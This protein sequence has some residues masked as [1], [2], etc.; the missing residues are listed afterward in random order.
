MNTAR[1]ERGRNIRAG[2]IAG[3]VAAV[4]LVVG[5]AYLI[6]SNRQPPAE[7]V[8]SGDGDARTGTG[9]ATTTAPLAAAATL[10]LSQV[11]WASASYPVDC[12]GQTSASDPIYAKPQPDTQVAIVFVTCTGGNGTPPSA[13]L[14]YDGAKSPAEPHLR[15]TLV[16]Y[17]DD[18]IPKKGK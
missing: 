6:S 1:G 7:R 8:V 11:A 2:R 12:G 4:G 10:P 3:A 18:W 17:Q 13:V 16:R 5:A 14:V 9:A 15:Q